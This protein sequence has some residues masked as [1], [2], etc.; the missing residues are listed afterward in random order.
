MKERMEAMMDDPHA[1][2]ER[3][4]VNQ[5]LRRMGHDPDDIRIR[6]LS[7]SVVDERARS[8]FAQANRVASGHLARQECKHSK[9]ENQGATLVHPV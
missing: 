4:E 6:A 2:R 8:I 9:R 1:Q 5:V 3:A 7:T